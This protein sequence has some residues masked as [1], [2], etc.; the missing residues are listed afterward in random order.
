TSPKKTSP[1]TTA[2]APF[3]LLS[4]SRRGP[5]G[6]EAEHICMATL[7]DDKA[8]EGRDLAGGADV[9][10]H[11]REGRREPRSD[12]DGSGDGRQLNQSNDQR[13]LDGGRATLV[14][15]QRQKGPAHGVRPPRSL[16]R[17]YEA[18][19]LPM[20]PEINHRKFR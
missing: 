4:K 7:Q 2:V 18:K 8:S 20:R 13:V 12:G 17:Y 11:R 3:L 19:S 9:T 5:S 6:R 14:S 1:T 16:P 10:G 15:P